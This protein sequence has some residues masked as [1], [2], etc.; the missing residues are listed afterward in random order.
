MAAIVALTSISAT[1]YRGG[2]AAGRPAELRGD[3]QTIITKTNEVI[4]RFNAGTMD[5]LVVGAV[6]GPYAGGAVSW[7]ILD[8]TNALTLGEIRFR[9][10]VTGGYRRFRIANGIAT[11]V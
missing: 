5:T 8:G 7:A 9:D 10:S 3:I 6:A 4:T 1:R 2:R 11:V